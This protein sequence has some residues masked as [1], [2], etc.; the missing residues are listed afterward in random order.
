[1]PVCLDD[2][3]CHCVRGLALRLEV[4]D[5]GE[6]IGSGQHGPD[7]RLASLGHLIGKALEERFRGGLQADYEARGPHQLAVALIR[8]HAAAGGDD[9]A[10]PLT[11]GGQCLAFQLAEPGLAPLPEQVCYGHAL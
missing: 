2:P 5:A 8:G 11:D 3:V 9:L 10:V 1:M 6:R 7:L 4:A